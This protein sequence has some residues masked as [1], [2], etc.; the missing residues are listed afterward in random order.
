[1]PAGRFFLRRFR[2]IAPGY[3]FDILLFAVITAA[4]QLLNLPS[5]SILG[6]GNSSIPTEGHLLN[7]IFLHGL[8]PKWINT[9]V[10]GGWYIGTIALMY[11]TF[12]MMKKILELTHA[13]NSRT[14]LLL[15]WLFAGISVGFWYLTSV[16]FPDMEIG[17]NTFV[18]FNILTQYPCFVIGGALYT[19]T[20]T[21]GYLAGRRSVL[22]CIGA[23]AVFLAATIV[24]FY[25]GNDFLF[26]LVP[27]C[28]SSFFACAMLMLIKV[29]DIDGVRLP[30]KISSLCHKISGV[31]YEMYLLHTLFAYFL[32]YYLR[33][34]LQ[35][36][37]MGG[38]FDYT[39][40]FLVFL[41]LLIIF[42][43]YSGKLLKR[44]LS[45]LVESIETK[46]SHN[47]ARKV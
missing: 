45:R 39:V 32:V 11:I 12:P 10:P 34:V 13:R 14:V 23:A 27:F 40:V 24:L 25:S 21:H 4:I 22:H 29:V 41:V 7:L 36:F 6:G 8:S 44:S 19:F 26:C 28:A 37:G 43:Y 35:H 42:S 20:N 33:K 38:I 1:M 5:Y 15:P 31:S 47:A 30:E 3:Y 2:A 17:N 18:Y 9:I 46:F 16:C